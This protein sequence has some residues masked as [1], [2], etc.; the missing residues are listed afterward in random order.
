MTAACSRGPREPER[1]S[2]EHGRELILKHECYDCHVIPG[3]DRRHGPGV[4]VSLEE[5]AGRNTISNGTV[6]LTR[7]TL[8]QYIQK[9]KTVNPRALMPGI[10]DAPD[11]A[12]DIAAYLMTLD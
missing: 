12:R 6:A 10:G 9:P 4:P 11:E 3:I 2:A 8:E 1:G 5:F 7:A